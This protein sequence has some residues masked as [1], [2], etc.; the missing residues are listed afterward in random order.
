MH[1]L[2]FLLRARLSIRGNRG[3]KAII[4]NV[5]L[6]TP[7]THAK[8][9]ARTELPDVPDFRL[10]WEKVRV[11]SRFCSGGRGTAGSSALFRVN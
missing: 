3:A 6:A 8:N 11:T 10:W 1:T 9:R 5:G 2:C 7:D 4:L